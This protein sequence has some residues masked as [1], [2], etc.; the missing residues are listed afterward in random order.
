M[1]EISYQAHPEGEQLLLLLRNHLLGTEG[2][3]VWAWPTVAGARLSGVSASSATL[4]VENLLTG[5]IDEPWRSVS[6]AGLAA[7]SADGVLL[8]WRLGEPRLSSA[9]V[10]GAHNLRV[11][12]RVS[13]YSRNPD[14]HGADVTTAW[15]DPVVRAQP[16]DFETFSGMPFSLGPSERVLARRAAAR[17]MLSFAAFTELADLRWLQVEID[18]SE[19]GNNGEADYVQIGYAHLGHPVRPRIG[20]DRGWTS[21]VTDLSERLRS[22]GGSMLGQEGTRLRGFGFALGRLERD[23]IWDTLAPELEEV[24][25]LGRVVAWPEPELPRYFTEQ[26]M[27]GTITELPETT[28]ALYARGAV[29]G[30][31]IERTA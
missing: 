19:G 4:G 12:Y 8:R 31:K 26:A 14:R 29:A 28:M 10:L 23:E 7:A 11:P 2:A 20:M 15:L 25:Q 22:Y 24:G 13:G 21:R 18:L 17:S 30:W 16:D 6:L 27:V 9:L 5:M 1:S 3:S